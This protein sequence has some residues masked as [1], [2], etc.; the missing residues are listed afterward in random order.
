MSGSLAS[1]LF[2]CFFSFLFGGALLFLRELLRGMLSAL[3]LLPPV[4][5]SDKRKAEK[6][7]FGGYLL[8]DLSFFIFGSAAYMIF[9]F[10]VH[11]GVFRMYSLF[12]LCAGGY[13][14]RGPAFR[15]GARPVCFLLSRILLPFRLLFRKCRRK[16][17]KKLDE[18]EEMV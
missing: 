13:L 4:L 15:F 8:F 12:L 18:T 11:N 6:R 16:K 17:A 10:A 7:Y 1:E 5:S 3:H 14:A 9:L 2:F